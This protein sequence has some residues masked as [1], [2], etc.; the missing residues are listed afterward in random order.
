MNKMT[1]KLQLIL[2]QAYRFSDIVQSTRM[3]NQ[4]RNNHYNHCL[5]FD[6]EKKTWE[7]EYKLLESFMNEASRANT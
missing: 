1:N 5:H 4:V 7:N 3:Y 2:L 6:F